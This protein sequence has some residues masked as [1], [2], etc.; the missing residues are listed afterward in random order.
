MERCRLLARSIALRRRGQSVAKMRP[1]KNEVLG[2]RFNAEI[3]DRGAAAICVHMDT[4]H[5]QRLRVIEITFFLCKLNVASGSFARCVF[6]KVQ[7]VAGVCDPSLGHFQTP[8]PQQVSQVR[9]LPWESKN[10]QFTLLSGKGSNC[11]FPPHVVSSLPPPTSQALTEICMKVVTKLLKYIVTSDCSAGTTH[12]SER[13]FLFPEGSWSLY[14]P[15]RRGMK[16]FLSHIPS[17]AEGFICAQRG[18]LRSNK[19]LKQF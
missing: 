15:A 16:T 18:L 9:R 14:T 13:N 19:Y 5:Y 4:S 10:R 11:Y 6:S 12:R 8:Q 2:L 1:A 3:A 7:I 17:D